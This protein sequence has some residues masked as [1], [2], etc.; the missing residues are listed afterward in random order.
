[1]AENEKSLTQLL[2]SFEGRIPRS[3]FL[4]YGVVAFLVL[5]IVVMFIDNAVGADG[6]LGGITYLLILYPI[7]AL[8]VKRCHDRGRSGWFVLVSA[9]PIVGIWYVVEIL[10]LPGIEGENKY[11]PNPTSTSP[12]P[13]PC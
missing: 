7:L 3:T 8:N 13:A 9:I 4:L 12:P 5:L 2:F 6:I 11:G 10:F 1:M